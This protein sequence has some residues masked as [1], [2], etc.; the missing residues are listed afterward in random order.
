M[1]L[2]SCYFSCCSATSKLLASTTIS[3]ISRTNS[4]GI[5]AEALFLECLVQWSLT[6]APGP[7]DKACGGFGLGLVGVREKGV[8]FFFPGSLFFCYVGPAISIGVT[9]HLRAVVAR[10][11]IQTLSSGL[12]SERSQ[13]CPG[14]PQDSKGSEFRRVLFLWLG[15]R[16][17][18]PLLGA[19]RK[20][21]SGPVRHRSWL[22][23]D[24]CLHGFLPCHPCEE[25][26]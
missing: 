26:D 22:A 1:F 11:D 24:F 25:P 7:K 16:L 9:S 3:T 12:G 6:E 18:A 15:F 21:G 23:N 20:G 13:G 4:L 5:R 17:G 14:L 8:H 19:A 10:S 2:P